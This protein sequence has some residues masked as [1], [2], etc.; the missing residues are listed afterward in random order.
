[1]KGVIN[2]GIQELV[3]CRF[4]TEAWQEVKRLGRASP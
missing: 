4:G 2:K 1:M 3:E